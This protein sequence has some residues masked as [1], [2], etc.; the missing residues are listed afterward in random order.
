MI[1]LGEASFW[2]CPGQR[3]VSPGPLQLSSKGI[4]LDLPTLT[5]P[6]TGWSGWQWPLLMSVGCHSAGQTQ[7]SEVIFTPFWPGYRSLLGPGSG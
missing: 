2:A 5:W 3:E 4:E 6:Q 1:S 7:S